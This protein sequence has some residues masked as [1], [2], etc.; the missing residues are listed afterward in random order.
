MPYQ[1]S[2]RGIQGK[3]AASR[4][5]IASG[6]GKGREDFYLT[7]SRMVPYKKMH[8]IIEAFANM[9]NRRL[10]VIGGGPQF[11]RCRALA[12]PNVQMLGYQPHAVLLSHM[13]RARAFIFSAEEDFGII[14]HSAPIRQYAVSKSHSTNGPLDSFPHRHASVRPVIVLARSAALQSSSSCTSS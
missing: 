6:I 10:V 8:L 3:Q 14:G 13:Q 9:P 5:G 4:C 1:F 2:R 11:K 12:T 7:S